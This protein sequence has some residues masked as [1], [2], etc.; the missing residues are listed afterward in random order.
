MHLLEESRRWVIFSSWPE[1]HSFYFYFKMHILQIITVCIKKVYTQKP[2][3][4]STRNEII[5]EYGSVEKV[6]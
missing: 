2:S 3:C 4:A 6:F 5:G 1:G